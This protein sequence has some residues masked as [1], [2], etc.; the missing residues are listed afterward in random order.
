MPKITLG[1]KS[2]RSTRALG[3]SSSPIARG[4]V[5]G[6][7]ALFAISCGGEP[8]GGRARFLSLGTGGTGGIYYPL[9][10]ALASLLS[11]ADSSRIYTA[12][13]TGGA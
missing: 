2:H 1:S 3:F 9:G 13:V 10:G 6:I 12:E 4:V 8:A 7:T 11:L 5:F